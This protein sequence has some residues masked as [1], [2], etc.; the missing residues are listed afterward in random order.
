MS[1]T[2]SG[3]PQDKTGMSL[4]RIPLLP[5]KVVVVEGEVAQMPLKEMGVVSTPNLVGQL[6]E[7]VGEEGRA[8]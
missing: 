2:T 8:R 1:A 7:V 6:R 5:L 3:G 4:V